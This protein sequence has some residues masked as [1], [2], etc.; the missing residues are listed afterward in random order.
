MGKENQCGRGRAIPESAEASS[1]EVRN[2]CVINR[3]CKLM[4]RI[5]HKR[6]NLINSLDYPILFDRNVQRV[7]DQA[8]ALGRSVNR[9]MKKKM[10][11]ES[12][13]S[14]PFQISPLVRGKQ[15]K[16]VTKGLQTM[17][18]DIQ[19]GNAVSTKTSKSDDGTGSDD[20]VTTRP[21]TTTTV[22][23]CCFM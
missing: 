22:Q 14:T 21:K 18:I 15:V 5:R 4:N 9:F 13:N 16:N 20:H 19:S 10:S 7:K 2:K 6:G 1:V 23:Y 12:P 8:H 3:I 17:M 11:G